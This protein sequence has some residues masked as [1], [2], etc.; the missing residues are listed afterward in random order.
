MDD[1]WCCL[2]QSLIS[3]YKLLPFLPASIR[4]HA[5]AGLEISLGPSQ[6]YQGA[7]FSEKETVISKRTLARKDAPDRVVILAFGVGQFSKK[8]TVLEEYE[9]VSTVSVPDGLGH[10]DLHLLPEG[11]QQSRASSRLLR[12]M[13]CAR[14][15]RPLGYIQC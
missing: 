11:A 14:A 4:Y 2:T 1:A 10:S 5:T 9:R 3:R 13:P 15:S 8:L 7:P 12:S 6:G